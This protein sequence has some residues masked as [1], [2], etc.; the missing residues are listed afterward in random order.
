[1]PKSKAKT[2]F[3]TRFF[4]AADVA[5]V[6]DAASEW[7]EVTALKPPSSSWDTA[8]VTH[9]RS[10][11][12]FR[13]WIKTLRDAG[14]A[15]IQVNLVKGSATDL[16][17]Q[18]ADAS[19]EAFAYQFWIPNDTVSGWLVKGYALVTSYEAEVPLG[20]R[21]LATARL[22]FTG[23]RTEAAGPLVVAP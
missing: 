5:D 16:A 8:E 2:G 23:A 14:E 22:K 10:A 20:D 13:E 6:S 12:Q 17:M 18:A 11:E 15:D 7:A 3:G 9:F 19:P 4:L 21:M 1:M